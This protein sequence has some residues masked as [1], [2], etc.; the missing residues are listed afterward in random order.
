M[1]CLLAH[2][3]A[4][5]MKA[6]CC[7]CAASG[8]WVQVHR[9]TR[10]VLLAKAVATYISMYKASIHVLDREKKGYAYSKKQN[11]LKRWGR[12]RRRGGGGGGARTAE[13]A[14]LALL[15]V[16]GVAHH[17]EDLRPGP[18]GAGGHP[19]PTSECARGTHERGTK[20]AGPEPRPAH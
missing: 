9:S 12:R 14:G 16:I 10:L 15:R 20:P 3:R 4:V 17:E 7:C 5:E 11:Q 1:K 8:L 19:H 6:V 18:G 13:G 2:R